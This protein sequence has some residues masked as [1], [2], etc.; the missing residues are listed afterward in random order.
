MSETV[1]SRRGSRL[2][3]FS[4]DRRCQQELGVARPTTLETWDPSTERD[5]E[6]RWESTAETMRRYDAV[7]AWRREERRQFVE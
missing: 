6:D 1:G 7:D 4:S 5:W 2:V 3:I